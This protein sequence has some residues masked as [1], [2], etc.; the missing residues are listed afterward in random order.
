MSHQLHGFPRALLATAVFLAMAHGAHA[1]STMSSELGTTGSAN[2][3][4]TTEPMQYDAPA[5]GSTGS[6]SWLPYTTRGYVGF[7]GGQADF[8]VA[9]T[10]GF[11]CDDSNRAFKVYTGG[12]FNQNFGLE[13]AYVQPGEA[14]RAGGE[15]EA[16]G[17]NLSLIG[18]L[19]FNETF[20]VFGKVGATYGWTDT[21]A[22][23]PGVATGDE[24]GVGASYGVGLNIFFTPNWGAVVEWERHRFEFAGDNKEDVEMTTVGVKYRF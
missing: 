17:L 3:A 5:A 16:K 11:S 1:Q 14:D 7:S 15:V 2:S 22:S 8:D 13:I 21:D 18:V 9:C 12:M 6:T 23:A 4:T 10:G 19:P 24:E 20:E